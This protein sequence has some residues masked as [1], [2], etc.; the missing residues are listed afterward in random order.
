MSDDLR[1]WFADQGFDAGEIA[2][3][4]AQTARV[5][6]WE[7]ALEQGNL[8]IETLGGIRP[9]NPNKAKEQTNSGDNSGANIETFNQLSASNRETGGDLFPQT[10]GNELSEIGLIESTGNGGFAWRENKLAEFVRNVNAHSG[11]DFKSDARGLNE[12]FAYIDELGAYGRDAFMTE[13][14]EMSENVLRVIMPNGSSRIVKASEIQA[15]NAATGQ[16]TGD[17]EKAVRASSR[18]GGLDWRVVLMSHA[19]REEAGIASSMGDT[20]ALVAEGR[21]KFG[22]SNELAYLYAAEWQQENAEAYRRGDA[23]ATQTTA[24]LLFTDPSQ[25]TEEQI[26]WKDGVVKPYQNLANSVSSFSTNEEH[27]NFISNYGFTDRKPEVAVSEGNAR[28][29]FRDL[30]Q[31]LFLAVPDDDTLDDFQR[32]FEQDIAAWS[33]RQNASLSPFSGEMQGDMYASPTANDAALGFIQDTDLYQDLYGEEFRR[34]GL[35]QEQYAA[36]FGNFALGSFED[37]N[38]VREAG[39]AG[40]RS[41]NLSDVG[42]FGATALGAQ[43]EN[44]QRMMRQA[45]NVI[46]NTP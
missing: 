38:L 26:N 10:L 24:E 36:R 28:D 12:A 37:P 7:D 11:Q 3:L 1:K 17:I 34:S 14:Y 42:A 35:T 41:G 33:Q 4:E 20:A 22:G 27:F 18:N 30:Y 16:S 31:S 40:M 43:D 9:A 25:L 32:N 46:R 5:T 21:R 23:G 8:S 19:A 13:Y 2:A 39:R 6:L 45:L 29:T 44:Q 15:I